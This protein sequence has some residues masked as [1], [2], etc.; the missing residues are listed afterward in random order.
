MLLIGEISAKG[1]AKK[2]TAKF[3]DSLDAILICGLPGDSTIEALKDRI[4][5]VR[6][7][8]IA[9]SELDSL[10]EEG[11][12]FILLDS[13]QTL[14]TALRDDGIAKGHALP[15][16]LTDKQARV[17]ED[18]PFDYLTVVYDV[19][20][21]E[22]TLDQLISLQSGV[23]MVGKHIVLESVGLPTVGELNLLRDLPADAILIQADKLNADECEKARA[24]IAE[25]EPR[26]ERTHKEEPSVGQSVG[27]VAEQDAGDLG[28]DDEEFDDP[29]D[30]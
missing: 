22:L 25:L 4:W 7:G 21:G 17:Y 29:D 13:D 1:A 23:S 10:K 5:G 16:D 30:F 9:E 14:A 12:D 2:V 11:C 19:E 27:A 26:R 28:G 20:P 6:V 15:P 18:L 3:A 24:T 8:K